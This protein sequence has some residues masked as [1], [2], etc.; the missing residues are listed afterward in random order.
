MLDGVAAEQPQSAL[1]CIETRPLVMRP[2]G[3]HGVVV[4]AIDL[5]IKVYTKK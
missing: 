3:K 2:A 5:V 4:K 1:V